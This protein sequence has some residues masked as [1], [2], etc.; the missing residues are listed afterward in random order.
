MTIILRIIEIVL[1]LLALVTISVFVFLLRPD[2][3]P[4]QEKTF[5][6]NVIPVATMVAALTTLL[7]AYAAFRSI[8][9]NREKEE[10]DRKERLINEIIEWVSDVKFKTL[11]ANTQTITLK[12]KRRYEVIFLAISD[13]LLKAELMSSRASENSIP[14]EKELN[15]VWQSAFF[16]SQLAARITGKKPTDEQR[17]RWSKNALDI[18]ARIDQL[19]EQG[20]LTDQA[21]Y[22]GQKDLLQKISSCLEKLVKIE[23]TL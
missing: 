2:W 6:S 9:S 19:E 8:R 21:M 1:G 5:G 4:F 22:D 11:Q 16:C 17:K 13:A 12:G 7:V 3:S 15:N 20:D 18:V 23:A 14:V 10:R